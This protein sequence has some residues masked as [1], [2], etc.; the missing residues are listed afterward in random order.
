MIGADGWTAG[1][2]VPVMMLCRMSHDAVV[3][4]APVVTDVVHHGTSHHPVR[5]H[6]T[7]TVQQPTAVTTV[8]TDELRTEIIKLNI[9]NILCLFISYIPF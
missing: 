5:C 8:H 1:C 2:I 9:H 7:E 6:E 4:Y 3:G